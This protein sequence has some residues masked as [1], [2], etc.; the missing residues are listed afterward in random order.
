MFV[1][2]V[3]K[4]CQEAEVA[5]DGE[6]QPVRPSSLESIQPAG[7]R[8]AVMQSSSLV[9][10]HKTPAGIEQALDRGSLLP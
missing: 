5:T 9:E 6:E 4:I 7:E 3:E 10:G 2:M 8:S 1:G